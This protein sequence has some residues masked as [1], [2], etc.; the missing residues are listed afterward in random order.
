MNSNT[1]MVSSDHWQL[2]AKQ[3]NHT[4][5]TINL[6]NKQFIHALF[7]RTST[8]LKRAKVASIMPQ[9]TVPIAYGTF[10]IATSELD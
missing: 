1:S 10:G 6:N 5:H 9:N 2:G 7:E 8:G 3:V 4:T